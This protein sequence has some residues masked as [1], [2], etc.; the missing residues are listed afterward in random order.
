VAD[1]SLTRRTLLSLAASA[2]A[3]TAVA[4]RG[5]AAHAQSPRRRWRN[6]RVAC[7]N[8][9]HGVGHDDVLDLE[10][11]ARLLERNRADV[12]GL[13]EVDRHWSERSDWVDQAAWFGQ[14]LRMEY[15]HGAN[16]DLDPPE[17]GLP[18]R[19]YGTAL[20]SR[21]PIISSRNTYL[22]WEEGT[23]QRGL[24]EITVDLHGT[25]LRVGN[26]HLQHRAQAAALRLVQAQRAGRRWVVV[27]AIRTRPPHRGSGS[28]T[29]SDRGTPSRCGAR[30]PRPL[31]PTISPSRSTT[32]CAKATVRRGPRRPTRGRRSAARRWQSE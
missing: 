27:R 25:E 3:V 20:L 15:V 19:R 22:P 13:Q 16:L 10:R 1:R 29:S 17:P 14:R 28:T 11:Q 18:R 8:I 30:S 24:L 23:E 6:L 21:W 4:A 12:I 31:R 26:T 5:T 32:S 2:V 7:F 9:H